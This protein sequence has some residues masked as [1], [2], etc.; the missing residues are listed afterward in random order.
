MTRHR[1]GTSG[2][3]ELNGE[4][5]GLAEDQLTRIDV[6]G[7]PIV[8]ARVEGSL[9]AYA[10]CLPELRGVDRRRRARRGDADLPELRSPLFPAAGPGA[11]STTRSS[12]SDPFRCSPRTRG[13]A[14]GAGAMSGNGRAIDDAVAARRRANM[15]TGL[16]GI[17]RGPGVRPG[18]RCRRR[19]RTQRGRSA[20][21][22]AA[23]GSR[24]STSTC[25]SSNDRR[26]LCAC[27]T[28]WAQRS[29]DPNLRPTG[30]RV[31]WLED[32]SLPDELWAR[33]EVPIGLAF[34]L[35]SSSVDGDG[36]DVPEPRRRDRVRAGALGLGGP[37][38][39]STRSSR[40]SSPTPRR[41]SSTGC[42]IRRAT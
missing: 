35:Y 6:R 22:S 19:G 24:R 26:I 20:A 17:R 42:P 29:G 11:R 3:H 4:V 32:F 37:L 34:F 27:A 28:C 18:A 14:G 10:R 38:R 16:R 2:W 21:T 31:V 5:D 25:S 9:L 12:I 1:P 36:G 8:V 15:V 23:S 39:R 41:S 30:S 33:L 7:T 40:R 13:G